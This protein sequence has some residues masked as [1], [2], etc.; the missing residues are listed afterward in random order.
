MPLAAPDFI[1]PDFSRGATGTYTAPHSTVDFVLASTPTY[2]FRWAA[3]LSDFG[4]GVT[5]AFSLEND[6]SGFGQLY[7]SR[8]WGD[9]LA[10]L[11]SWR[12]D[13]ETH[14]YLLT[15]QDRAMGP[16]GAAEDYL[17]H[18]WQTLTALLGP[19]PGAAAS[20]ERRSRHRTGPRWRTDPR[21][22]AGEPLP[23]AGG[24]IDGGRARDGR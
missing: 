16:S 6:F 9:E 13:G 7:E 11:L 12:Q 3:L 20:I 5:G 17:T 19:A 1:L 4:G 15:G 23:Q 22:Q 14:V 2:P 18:R 21:R 8:P 24:Q 10:A